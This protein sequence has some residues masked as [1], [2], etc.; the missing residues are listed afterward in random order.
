M[1]DPHG[2]AHT[3]RRL[4]APPR[5]RDNCNSH[6]KAGRPSGGGTTGKPRQ[7]A[8]GGVPA[9][10]TAGMAV[11]VVAGS[12]E[13]AWFAIRAGGQMAASARGLALEVLMDSPDRGLARL[14]MFLTA[15]AVSGSRRQRPIP[16]RR[17]RWL[18]WCT[19]RPDLER[20]ARLLPAQPQPRGVL[21]VTPRRCSGWMRSKS[22]LLRSTPQR[23]P[24][25]SRKFTSSTGPG[26]G[27]AWRPL[28]ASFDRIWTTLITS[29]RAVRSGR[30]RR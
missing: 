2:L 25:G 13:A 1:G 7:R 21:T 27:R 5:L 9:Q 30:H 20:S 18:S 24:S 4:V 10:D 19:A 6:P 17:D 12:T 8:G 22:L 23:D 3:S 14:S 11:E 26:T 28:S 29:T 16:W 15:H